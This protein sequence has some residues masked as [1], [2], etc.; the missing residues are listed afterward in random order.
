MEISPLAETRS[1]V[2]ISGASNTV[3]L[4]KSSGPMR[5]SGRTAALGGAT[6]SAR[7]GWKSFVASEGARVLRVDELSATVVPATCPNAGMAAMSSAS[8][9]NTSLVGRN[10]H[11]HF[12]R[13]IPQPAL[14]PF[15][16]YL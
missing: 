3:M 2:F 8:H 14:K 15:K 11:D 10:L 13:A 1:T 4:S 12:I 5:E 9:R 7:T 16:P 6:T